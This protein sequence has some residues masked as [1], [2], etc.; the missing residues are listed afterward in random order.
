MPVRG[1]VSLGS[2]TEAV[3][4]RGQASRIRDIGALERVGL[5]VLLLLLS[6]SLVAPWFV[7]DPVIPVAPPFQAPSL[8]HVL[9]TDD[10]GQDVF[11]RVIFGLRTSWLSAAAVI[12]SAIVIGG[13]IG[14]VA[15]ARGG[16]VD[17]LLMRLTDTFLALPGPVLAIAVAATLGASLR[18]TVIGI[19]VVWWPWYARLVRGEVRAL[20][21]R[22]HVDAARLS[23]VSAPRLVLRHLLPGALP[24]V[25]V[26]ASLD[27]Q[28][29]VLTLAG[30]SFI[31]LGAPPPA[32]E[33][34][35]MA[36]R[37]A[38][39]LF[40]SPWIPLAPGCAVFILAVAAN[41]AGD[42]VRD[43]FDRS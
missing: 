36:A 35:A 20:A 27:I 19:A 32:P 16:W 17:A 10:V 22:P 12:A 5:V 25:I 33:L 26:T 43:L 40:A 7:V 37:G 1:V 14:L 11:S 21:A 41:L 23:G 18:N 9:G 8:Q 4:R 24:P 3:T 28:I 15:G 2:G 42:G 39:Y 38:D 13:A 6:T 34:G 30:L 31:G 29:L